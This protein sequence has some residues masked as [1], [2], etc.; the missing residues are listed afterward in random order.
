MIIT[1]KGHLGLNIWLEIP[2]QSTGIEDIILTAW[3][4]EAMK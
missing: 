3:F 2:N 1:G 4:K